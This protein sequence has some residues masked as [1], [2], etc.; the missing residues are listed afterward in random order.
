MIGA[1]FGSSVDPRW[2]V[3][4]V[5]DVE[6]TD[7][8]PL[9]RSVLERVRAELCEGNEELHVPVHPLIHYLVAREERMADGA[10]EDVL[11]GIVAFHPV[12]AITWTP[13]VVILPEHRG[14][15]SAVLRAGM[16]WMFRSTACEKLF[17]APPAYNVAMIRCFEKCGFDREGRSP[18]SFRWKGM[19]HDRVLMGINKENF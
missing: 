2:L 10:V 13:H 16:A 9:I 4:P 5:R 3:M 8:V 17:A 19:V 12:N 14:K 11:V 6:R 1:M 7:D 15:G 18:C